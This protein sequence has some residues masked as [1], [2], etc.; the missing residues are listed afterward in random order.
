MNKNFILSIYFFLLSSCL[1][2]GWVSKSLGSDLLASVVFFLFIALPYGF[3][4]SG[5]SRAGTAR[6]ATVEE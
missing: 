5:T 2:F 3:M 4:I 6:D 1:Y